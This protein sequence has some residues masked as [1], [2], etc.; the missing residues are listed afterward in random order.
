MNAHFRYVDL[1]A[2]RSKFV[3]SNACQKCK[4]AGKCFSEQMIAE[5]KK[6]FCDTC[7]GMMILVELK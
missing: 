2:I 3:M 7:I 5:V 4:D 1:F 6:M